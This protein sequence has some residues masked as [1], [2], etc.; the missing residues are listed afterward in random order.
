MFVFRESG[1]LGYGGQ[2]FV[3]DLTSSPG[4]TQ[5]QVV[6]SALS[7]ACFFED[8]CCAEPTI[9]NSCYGTQF[10]W[11]MSRLSVL[12]HIH[13]CLCSLPPL[14]PVPW[15]SVCFLACTFKYGQSFS[16]RPQKILPPY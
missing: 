3:P 7:K 9:P 10:S 8:S 1:R 13:P 15:Y 11:R 2:K 5:P 4:G 14:C 12:C 6:I 16:F